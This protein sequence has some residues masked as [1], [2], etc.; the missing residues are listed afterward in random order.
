VHLEKG[1]QFSRV[2]T[3]ILCE[4]LKKMGNNE[5]CQDLNVRTS[6]PPGIETL[7]T[8]QNLCWKTHGQKE[9]NRSENFRIDPRYVKKWGD[10]GAKLGLGERWEREKTNGE[11]EISSMLIPGRL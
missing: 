2:R 5:R 9:F 8:E 4:A 10:L 7:M 11:G 3:E 6:D 1:G